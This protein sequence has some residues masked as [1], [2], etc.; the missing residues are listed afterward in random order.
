MIPFQELVVHHD[1]VQG[2]DENFSVT[3]SRNG[4]AANIASDATVKASIVGAGRSITHV[5][6]VTLAN[7]AVAD[8]GTAAAWGSGVV[9]VAFESADMADCPAGIY[10]LEI[11]VDDSGKTSWFQGVRVKKHTIA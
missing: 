7:D 11:Q 9:V 5:G 1:L 3:L 4:T 8:D 10:E 2:D 6:P